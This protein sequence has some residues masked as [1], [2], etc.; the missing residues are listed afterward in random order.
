M[1]TVIL[2]EDIVSP[3]SDNFDTSLPPRVSKIHGIRLL[4][5]LSGEVVELEK[6][7]LNSPMELRL[8]VDQEASSDENEGF[9]LKVGNL[10][11]LNWQAK[12]SRTSIF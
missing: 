1:G 7:E 3:T 9:S 8:E 5:P 11:I 10:F 4:N 6:K 2:E 12:I